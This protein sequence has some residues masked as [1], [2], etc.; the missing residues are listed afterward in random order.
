MLFIYTHNTRMKTGWIVT[1]DLIAPNGGRFMPAK[2]N[3]PQARLATEVMQLMSDAF[4]A[5]DRAKRPTLLESYKAACALDPSI[6]G[7]S[8]YLNSTAACAER[9]LIK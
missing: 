7:F 9:I 8:K 5:G 4:K 3:H 2:N 6:E 1:E